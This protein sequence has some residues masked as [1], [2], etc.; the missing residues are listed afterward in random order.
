[1]F[2]SLIS[3]MLVPSFHASA[4]A[5]TLKTE[6]AYVSIPL[7]LDGVKMKDFATRGR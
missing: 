7:A 2:S 1:M 3:S 6:S 4:V 5:L